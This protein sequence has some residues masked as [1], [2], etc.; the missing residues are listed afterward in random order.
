MLSRP[1]I[2][3]RKYPWLALLAPY[4]SRSND[5]AAKFT[6]TKNPRTGEPRR[7][8]STTQMDLPL[9]AREPSPPA[10]S[11]HGLRLA[12]HHRDI[13]RCHHFLAAPLSG[14]T[15]ARFEFATRTHWDKIRSVT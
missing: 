5:A 4:R 15:R 11:R 7:R 3:W 12:R 6:A 9:A 2:P 14:P 1:S 8:A 13:R 10:R